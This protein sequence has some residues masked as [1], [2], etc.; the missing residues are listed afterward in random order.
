[1]QRAREFDLEVRADINV[2]SL[3]D[4]AFVL[5]IIFVITAPILQGGIEVEVPQ[6]DVNPLSVQENTL[7]VSVDRDGLVYLGETPVERELFAS[8]FDQ[9]IAGTRPDRVVIKSD[10]L[11]TWGST[12][13]VISI[14]ASSGVTWAVVGEQR[15]RR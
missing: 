11:S 4:V 13:D 15:R 9:L 6:G 14:V 7:I 1:M 3:V 5:L 10:S 2:T 8:S 12:F